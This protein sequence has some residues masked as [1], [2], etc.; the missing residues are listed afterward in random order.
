[1]SVRVVY[2]DTHAQH[3]PEHDVQAGLAAP[4]VEQPARVERILEALSN[5]GS[6]R[7]EQQ[8][9]HGVGPI[10]AVHDGGLIAFLRDAWQGWRAA[11]ATAEMFPDTILHP[12]LRE[13]MDPRANEPA[14]PVAQL[15]FW[16]FDT[17]TPIMPG[18]YPAARGAVDVALTAMDLV[19]NG[20]RIA[21]GLCRPPGH[22]A[23]HS[24][25]GGFCY[26]NNA[27]IAAQY[28]VQRTGARVAVL[29]LDYHHGNGIQQIFYQRSDVLFVSLHADPG[30]AYPYFTGSAAE[31]GAGPGLGATRNIALPVGATDQ[32]YLSA[33]DD[34]LEALIRF[35]PALTIVSLGLDTYAQD[36]LGDFSLSTPVYAEC[37]RRAA[38]AA[39]RLVVLQEGGY[40]LPRLG[41]NVRQWLVGAESTYRIE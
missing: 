2:S 24:V 8:T 22:H 6:F 33:L 19:L 40:Y 3:A 38:S 4:H 20:E 16:C 15:G 7:L 28:A 39:N 31:T 18:T 41:E 35:A 32:L 10:E 29:D 21:Y 27:A 13:G 23:A 25:Y 1:L 30:R 14:T 34:A 17:G 11:G 36:P 5:D 26:F 9:E 12:G 37:G